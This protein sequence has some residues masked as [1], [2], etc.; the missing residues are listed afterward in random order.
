MI[1]MVHRVRKARSVPKDHRV[2]KVRWVPRVRRV[3]KVRWV[4][5]VRKA[6]LV[7]R[8]LRENQVLLVNPEYI[9]RSTVLLLMK[10]GMLS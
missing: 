6:I 5:R 9:R 3:N 10:P 2:N 1:L 8:D 7:L 4:P